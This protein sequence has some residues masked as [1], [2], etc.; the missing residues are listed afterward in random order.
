MIESCYE[1]RRIISRRMLIGRFAISHP[2]MFAGLG[3]VSQWPLAEDLVH[4]LC[5]LG[6]RGADLVAVDGLG[7]GCTVVADQESNALD[8]DVVRGQDRLLP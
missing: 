7:G 8:G 5:A 6:E 3:T 1:K 4:D 2:E